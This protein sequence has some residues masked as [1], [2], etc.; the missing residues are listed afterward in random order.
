MQT[1]FCVYH[2]FIE[3][4]DDDSDID[5]AVAK[6]LAFLHLK[7]EQIEREAEILEDPVLRQVYSFFSLLVGI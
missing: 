3:D 7:N 2:A 1:S 6:K 5:G 4:M